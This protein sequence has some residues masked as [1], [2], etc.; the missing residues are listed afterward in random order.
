MQ[1]IESTLDEDFNNVDEKIQ[2]LSSEVKKD[3]E[4]LTGE[5]ILKTII[6]HFSQEKNEIYENTL[7]DLS[8]KIT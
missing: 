2:H 6:G 1:T 3:L 4:Q 5:K 7:E 8:S